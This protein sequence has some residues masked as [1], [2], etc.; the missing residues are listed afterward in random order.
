[1][2][3]FCIIIFYYAI[4]A[5]VLPLWMLHF[6]TVTWTH[7]AGAQAA[8]QL[9]TRAGRCNRCVVEQCVWRHEYHRA[10][11][12][13]VTRHG[14]K[15]T[16][17]GSD[18]GCGSRGCWSRHGGENSMTRCSQCRATILPSFRSEGWLLQSFF[19]YCPPVCV[20]MFVCACVRACVRY[21][22]RP[23]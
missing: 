12:L 9:C 17:L 3:Y 14:L 19:V 11:S 20:C 1:M 7:R 5:M 2:L 23:L 22:S 21:L 15:W 8:R 4:L 6:P 16:P 10:K 18:G 13:A